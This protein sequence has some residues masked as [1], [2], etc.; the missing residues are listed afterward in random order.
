MHSH[1]PICPVSP[2]QAP[3]LSSWHRPWESESGLLG[4][5]GPCYWHSTLASWPGGSPWPGGHHPQ[6]PG[7]DCRHLTPNSYTIRASTHHSLT[8]VPRGPVWF[9]VN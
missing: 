9:E 8:N 3:I 1:L 4:S 2:A 6:V 5:K 7:Q